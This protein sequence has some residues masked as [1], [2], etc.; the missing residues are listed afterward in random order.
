MLLAA[1]GP[2]G[3]ILVSDGTAATGMPDGN[4]RLGTFEVKVTGGVCRGADGKLAGSTL[5]LDRALRNMVAL[6]VPL[7]RCARHADGKSRAPA[8][9]RRTQGRA[10]AGC[11]RGHGFSRR[12]N[13]K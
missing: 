2:R 6:G 13:W 12:T 8:G 1:K 7:R 10:R 9:P 11:G 3:V 4:Y 5:T